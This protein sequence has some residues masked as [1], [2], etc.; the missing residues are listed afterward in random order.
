[1]ARVTHR[2]M[3]WEREKVKRGKGKEMDLKTK[4][5]QQSEEKQSNLLNKISEFK[6]T[7]YSTI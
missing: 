4:Q 5:W 7:H 6:I 3:P 2:P 1:M